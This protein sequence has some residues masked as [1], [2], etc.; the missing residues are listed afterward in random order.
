VPTAAA[1]AVLRALLD[2]RLAAPGAA[3]CVGLVSLADIL[4]EL[5]GL[6]I[7]TRCESWR[8]GAVGLFPGVLGD[9]FARLPASVR[10]AHAGAAL[11]L[12][13][14]AVSA[15]RGPG[16]LL[17]QVLLGLPPRGRH[18]VQVDIDARPGGEIW[19]RRFGRHRFSS[20]L[21]AARADHGQ[22]EEQ[23]GPL[24]FR[25]SADADAR[26]FRWTQEGWRLGPVPMPNWLAPSV[27]ARSFERDG[28]YRFSVLATHPWVGVAVAYAGR[29]TARA[30]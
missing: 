7:T 14:R 1:S 15:G 19:R 26:G 24:T 20:R 18:A 5:Q 13:G 29:L 2:G 25:F 23:L 12:E 3:T 27:R 30:A 4:R 28:V 9:A 6:A 8:A 17:G 16:A 11:S 22:F 10:Q 21:R